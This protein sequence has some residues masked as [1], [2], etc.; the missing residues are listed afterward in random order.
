GF[1]AAFVIA[2]LYYDQLSSSLSLWIPYPELSHDSSW[3]VFLNSL[4]LEAAFYNAIS[5]A[6]IFFAV[7]VILQV[8]ASMLDFVASLPFLNSINRILGGVLGFLE[9]YLIIFI[10]LY[11]L[12]L[13]PIGSIQSWI[14]DSP[15]ALLIIEH[16]PYLSD[17]LQTMW[18]SDVEDLLIS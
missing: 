5:F 12:A 2:A 3:A 10:I 17:K 16:T 4:P 11:I 18:F 1:I 14:G 7:K 13:T 8:M 6:I 9:V 15:V